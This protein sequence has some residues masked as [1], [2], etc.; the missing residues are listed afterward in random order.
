MAK[1]RLW[2][3]RSGGKK[4]LERGGPTRGGSREGLDPRAAASRTPRTAW[5]SCAIAPER[6]SYRGSVRGFVSCNWRG[7]TKWKCGR[8]AIAV[9]P[10][11]RES[12]AEAPTGPLARFRGTRGVPLENPGRVV[13]RRADRAVR[14]PPLGE[15]SGSS[16][17]DQTAPLSPGSPSPAP[18]MRPPLPMTA[19]RCS[20]GGPSPL[21]AQRAP[22]DGPLRVR[23]GRAHQRS[24]A[25]A[26]AHR[27][28]DSASA[29]RDWPQSAPASR[30]SCWK[31]SSRVN[32]EGRDWAGRSVR[33][34]IAPAME[35][36]TT[37]CH[38]TSSSSG[39]WAWC[40]GWSCRG[41]PPQE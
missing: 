24:A 8:P 20:T 13:P 17:R 26:P 23:N 7:V 15:P 22:A 33:S 40:S 1:G 10:C 12:C 27:L 28:H 34:Q 5:D 41:R 30:I 21:F 35:L 18:P 2:G 37:L 11:Q 38:Q 39:G 3:H 6:R 36:G 32:G 16:P 25:L 29:G 4:S 14:G 19:R 31:S 9:S